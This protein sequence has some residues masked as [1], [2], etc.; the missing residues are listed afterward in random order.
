VLLFW[1]G[2][3]LMLSL[4]ALALVFFPALYIY[5]RRKYMPVITRIFQERPL[6]VIPRGQPLPGAEEVWLPTV[7]GLQLHGCYLKAKG[8]RR[9]VILFGL[10]YGSTC[11]SCWPYVEHLVEAGFDV[12][13]CEPRNQGQS[14]RL[15]GYEPLQWV[16]RFEVEDAR[17]ALD[18]LKKRADVDPRGIGLFGISKGA[19]AG[20]LAAANDPWV[21]CLVTDGAFATRTTLIPYMQQWIRIYNDQYAIQQMIPLS[22]YVQIG[23]AA[24]RQVERQ[25]GCRFPR[26]DRLIGRLAPRPLLMIHGELDT[27]IKP[28]MARALFE[29]AGE[30][31]EFWLVPQAKHNQ[32][33]QAAGAEYRQRVLDFFERHLA[34]GSIVPKGIQGPHMPFEDPGRATHS[35]PT[36]FEDSGRATLQMG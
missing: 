9:G 12:F 8:R 14:G 4:P 27:Y 11:W 28:E 24:V 31:R 22:Y 36:P 7:G 35:L 20:L 18:Y 6:F 15:P 16:T 2:L 17:A 30:P 21:R 26:L 25:R 5:L 3:A 19:G 13:A 10:E 32:A 29:Q 33:L 34:G 1:I 23:S